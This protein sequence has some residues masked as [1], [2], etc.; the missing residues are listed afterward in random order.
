MSVPEHFLFR[1]THTHCI[2]IITTTTHYYLTASSR[3]CRCTRYALCVYLFYNPSKKYWRKLM[4]FVI[5]TLCVYIS[6]KYKTSTWPWVK[7]RTEVISRFTRY[8]PPSKSIVRRRD[9]NLNNVFLMRISHF[10]LSYLFIHV[11]P[12]RTS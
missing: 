12:N 1:R 5:K 10:F 2:I 7:Q 6:F 8:P 11:Q 4:Y 9:K 3:F